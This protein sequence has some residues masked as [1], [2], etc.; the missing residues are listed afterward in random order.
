MYNECR[1]LAT[2]RLY[3]ILSHVIQRLTLGDAEQTSVPGLHIL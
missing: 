1:S 3:E 2:L